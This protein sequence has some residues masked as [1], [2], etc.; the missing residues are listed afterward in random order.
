MV[1]RSHSAQSELTGALRP[2]GTSPSVN[3]DE[4]VRVGVAAQPQDETC[5]LPVTHLF[6]LCRA[7][8]RRASFRPPEPVGTRYNGVG[9]A[10]RT[11]TC[12]SCAVQVSCPAFP[13]VHGLGVLDANRFRYTAASPC[14]E[15]LIVV[16]Q[17]VPV[18]VA[19]GRGSAAR[20]RPC[21]P[22]P[23][24]VPADFHPPCLSSSSIQQT[25]ALSLSLHPSLR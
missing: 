6:L 5:R 7:C 19:Y 9:P 16:A 21:R 13:G 24:S 22:T 17:V 4:Y 1:G 25:L 20:T 3:E 18:I 12:T 23:P 2:D 15:T 14:C 11:I 10:V 8:Q